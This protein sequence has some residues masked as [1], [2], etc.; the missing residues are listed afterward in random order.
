MLK[1]GHVYKL[2]SDSTEMI[3]IGSTGKS[4]AHRLSKHKLHRKQYLDGLHSYCCSFLLIQFADVRIEPIV[5]V[6]FVDRKR[7]LQ[8]EREMQTANPHCVN[9]ARPNDPIRT[10]ELDEKAKSL[11]KEYYAANKD[12]AKEYYVENKDR[13]SAYG[14][15]YYVKNKAHILARNKAHREE[16]KKKASSKDPKSSSAQP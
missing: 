11:N 5:T 2:C 1:E 7:L 13:F 8:L 15:E 14:A 3:Y 4:L 12:H 9:V 16:K 6:P 10:P